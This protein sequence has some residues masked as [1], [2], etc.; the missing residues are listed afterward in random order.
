MDDGESGDTFLSP[1]NKAT[2][3]EHSAVIP[4]SLRPTPDEK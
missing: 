1:D 4:T 3:K 2:K